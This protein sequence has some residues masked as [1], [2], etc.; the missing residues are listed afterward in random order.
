MTQEIKLI[1]LLRKKRS[2]FETLLDLSESERHLSLHEWI[3]LLEQKRI[4]L[5][6]IDKIDEALEP[7]AKQLTHIS[8]EVSEEIEETKRVIE[9]ILEQDTLNLEHR[10]KSLH[11]PQPAR[12]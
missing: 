9:R 2:F 11:F 6:I 4:L 1:T 3:T 10:K 8:Q 7:F 12:K 5:S